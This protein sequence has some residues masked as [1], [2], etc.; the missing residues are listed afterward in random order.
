[1]RNKAYLFILSTLFCGAVNGQSVE[2]LLQLQEQQKANEQAGR[3]INVPQSQIFANADANVIGSQQASGLPSQ[4]QYNLQ[5]RQGILL[6]G[7]A[8]IRQLLPQIDDELSPPYGAN[9]FAGGYETE[10]SDGL[11]DNYLI[12]AGDKINIWMWGAVSFSNVVTVDNQGNIFIPNIGPVN[13]LNVPASQVNALVTSKIKSV[14]KKNVQVYVNLLTATPVSVF[15]AGSVIR[16]GQYAGMASDS[17]LYYLKR[18]GG[19]DSDRGSYREIN[20]IRNGETI[21]S[22]DLYDF[23][24]NGRLANISFKDQDVIFVSEQKAVISVSGKVRNPFR[25]EFGDNTITGEQLIDYAKPLTITSHVA[26]MGKR[27]NEPFSIYLPLADFTNYQLAD[28]DKL[29]FNDDLHAQIYDIE[30]MGSYLGPSYF[31]VNKSTKLHDLL[32][33]VEIDEALADFENIYILRESVKLEQKEILD[34]SLDRLE[35][36]VFFAP[37]GSTGEASIR[38]QEARLV[39]EFV[40]RAREVEPLGRVVVADNGKIANIALEQGDKIVIPA[41]TDLIQIG[42]EVLMPQAVVYNAQATLEDYIAW[43]GGYSDR[44]DYEKL[45]VIHAN[46]LSEFIDLE[47]NWYGSSGE[48]KLVAGD[49]ILVLPKIETKTMQTVKDITQIL[50]QIAVTANAIN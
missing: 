3:Q 46:G 30:I 14:Y 29:F 8:D 5:A 31:A 15:I 10:R 32:S 40:E 50:Y 19:I 26:V 24:K 36:S 1:M 12:A 41:K 4:G 16:P 33:H 25:F 38:T 13:V 7:E 9:I 18:A 39:S 37:T 17:I 6:P 48:T 45:V 43:A 42:G 2:E 20:V 34:K 27:N 35:R 21:H 11:N 22:V 44:A 28:G 49:K 47:S 23:V